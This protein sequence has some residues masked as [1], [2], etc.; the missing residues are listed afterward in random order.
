[1]VEADLSARRPHIPWGITALALA[2]AVI[3]PALVAGFTVRVLG[4]PLAFALRIALSMGLLA[5]AHAVV[6]GL[7]AVMW[8]LRAGRALSWPAA[9][10]G[11]FVIG[12]VP[13]ALWAW[14]LWRIRRGVSA[15]DWNGHALVPTL[16]NGIP[17]LA[18]W[19]HYAR[20]ALL[21]GA[22]GCIGALAFWWVRRRL[23]ARLARL[24][25]G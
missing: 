7:P 8:L 22:F 9:V 12:C 10:V 17:T 21:A 16:V 14:P 2:A 13:T 23:L 19:L 6:L 11:G 5:L 18:G 3:A 15:S 4:V 1:M 24:G 20:L 25:V